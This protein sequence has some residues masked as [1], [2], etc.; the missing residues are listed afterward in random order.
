MS[1]SSLTAILA[2]PDIQAIRRLVADAFI[3]G[4][5]TRQY[6]GTT[7]LVLPVVDALGD[8]VE[9][10]VLRSDE[11]PAHL[12]LS[13]LGRT[14]LDVCTLAGEVK[15][16]SERERL[17]RKAASSQ[18]VRVV[19]GRLEVETDEAAV[20]GAVLAL[21]EAVKEAHYLSQYGRQTIAKLFRE[22]VSIFLRDRG[23]TVRRDYEVRGRSP[24]THQVDFA[25][26]NGIP[27]YIQAIS[28]ED[29]LRASLLTFYD[30]EGTHEFVPAAVLDDEEEYT[31]KTFQHFA[32]RVPHVFTWSQR[33]RLATF[34]ESSGE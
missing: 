8:C 10:A 6:R 13:D 30:L 31:N 23:L 18:G 20:G 15:A 28:S 27:K 22:E 4:L 3:D 32:F 2:Q 34:L 24:V 26:L 11:K 29:K 21:A 19:D 17:F 14:W 12:V 9:I 1:T 16:A 33:E 5:S 25:K 7:R